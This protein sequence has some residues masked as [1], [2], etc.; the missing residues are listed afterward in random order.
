MQDAQVTKLLFLDHI[1]INVNIFKKLP[2]LST[3]LLSIWEVDDPEER[4]ST[5]SQQVK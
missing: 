1:C 5:F 3:V 4:N 2:T